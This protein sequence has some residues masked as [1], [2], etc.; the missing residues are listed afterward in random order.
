MANN[1][2]PF[3]AFP[4]DK[5]TLEKLV[6]KGK[7]VPALKKYYRK[8]S[9]L[10]L[11]P[12]KAEA[13]QEF[14]EFGI[15]ADAG[16]KW[17][18]EAY[19]R[20]E[21]ATP[22]Q[23]KTW[24]NEY[25]GKPSSIGGM[26]EEELAEIF[27]ATQAKIDELETHNAQLQQAVMDALRG[28][29]INPGVIRGG[30][31]PALVRDLQARLAEAER[32]YQRGER[33]LSAAMR[34]IGEVQRNA[35]DLNAELDAMRRDKI[36]LQRKANE[37]EAQRDAVQQQSFEYKTDAKKLEGTLK[38]VR[39]AAARE[40][41]SSQ[42]SLTAAEELIRQQMKR[43]EEA[44]AAGLSKTPIGPLL[45]GIREAYDATKNAA[46][47]ALLEKTADAWAQ[48]GLIESAIAVYASLIDTDRT[49]RGIRPKYAALLDRQGRLT[50]ALKTLDEEIRQGNTD[51]G[52]AVQRIDL[53]LKRD[54][55]DLIQA[56][57]S[58]YNRRNMA[59]GLHRIYAAAKTNGDARAQTKTLLLGHGTVKDHAVVE[60]LADAIT[61]DVFLGTYPTYP[62][63]QMIKRT[64][65]SHLTAG[66]SRYNEGNIVKSVKTRFEK[67]GEPA[68]VA[69]DLE[70]NLQWDETLVKDP[71]RVRIVVKQLVETL[72]RPLKATYNTT[73]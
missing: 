30:A 13:G 50:D 36:A 42:A 21:A 43:F 31:D 1:G 34:S 69:S 10:I 22:D 70:R 58:A 16:F 26:S 59:A 8:S 4:F 27:D 45:D 47:L 38:D 40:K 53:H 29:G 2:N 66:F 3:H 12:D 71:T 49:Q 39:E 68:A 11:H 35:R 52:V 67:G 24:L 46:L 32:Q 17:L 44:K 37:Y 48:D 56:G 63:E 64:L 5:P 14:V 41:A 62:I 51:N 23:I 6:G 60:R 33:D 15:K 25:D 61:E 55:T 18:S 9:I 19:Q 54:Y 28:Q 73:N 72:Y 57:F 20:I 65:Q 7:L